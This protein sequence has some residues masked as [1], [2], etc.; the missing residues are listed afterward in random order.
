MPAY[1]V[2]FYPQKDVTSTHYFQ[3]RPGKKA[4]MELHLE[5]TLIPYNSN[6]PCCF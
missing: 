3:V 5:I 4:D 1:I 6:V 2:S